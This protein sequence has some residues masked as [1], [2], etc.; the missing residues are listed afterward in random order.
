VKKTLFTIALTLG[1]IAM[2]RA[3]GKVAINSATTDDGVRT[4]LRVVW[5]GDLTYAVSN[6]S[7]YAVLFEDV[8]GGQYVYLLPRDQAKRC[9]EMAGRL[10]QVLITD[11]QHEG[12]M[13]T[14]RL[15]KV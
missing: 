6:V 9:G 11:G 4:R 8:I 1:V 13:Y 10:T 2:L 12:G 5:V 3:V 15:G 7:H 14:A